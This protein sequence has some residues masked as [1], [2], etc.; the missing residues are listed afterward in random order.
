MERLGGLVGMS[1]VCDLLVCG[2]ALCCEMTIIVFTLFG[3]VV[4]NK[5]LYCAAILHV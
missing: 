1:L 5:K 3:C 2:D 4:L